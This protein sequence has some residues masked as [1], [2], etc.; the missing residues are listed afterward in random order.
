VTSRA[1]QWGLGLATVATLEA[2]SAW[3]DTPVPAPTLARLAEL[4]D[5]PIGRTMWGIGDE[6]PGRDGRRARAT[7]AAFTVRQRARYGTW[8]FLRALARPLEAARWKQ[9]TEGPRSS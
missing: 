8:L 7:W 3:L 6:Q 5:D 1:E 2:A 4:A 9:H